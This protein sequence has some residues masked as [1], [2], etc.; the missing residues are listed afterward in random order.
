MNTMT[1]NQLIAQL[2]E[3]ASFGLGDTVIEIDVSGVVPGVEYGHV[4]DL[5]YDAAPNSGI[6]PYA[7]LIGSD[8]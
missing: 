3:A 5:D 1:V 4:T 7:M 8:I 6:A 2:Q